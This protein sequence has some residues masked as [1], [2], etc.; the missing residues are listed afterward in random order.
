[1]WARRRK[2]AATRDARR[3]LV[4]LA[5]LVSLV[6]G[7]S[8]VEDCTP[9]LDEGEQLRVTIEE[10]I[11]TSATVE[12][13]PEVCNFQPMPGDELL[14]TASE[15]VGVAGENPDCKGNYFLG[16]PVGRPYED[17]DF[18]WC[19]DPSVELGGSPGGEHGGYCEFESA[20]CLLALHYAIVLG[21]SRRGSNWSVESGEFHVELKYPQDYLTDPPCRAVFDS[22]RTCPRRWKVRIERLSRLEQE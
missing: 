16:P 22:R 19:Y 8:S 14:L 13:T 4:G 12:A 1:M 21:D 11:W 9:P 2:L 3:T 20:S 6:A 18:T 10:T 7:C 17:L 5:A 15:V